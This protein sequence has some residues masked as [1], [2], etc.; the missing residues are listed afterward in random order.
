ML[1]PAEEPYH[2][3]LSGVGTHQT[4]DTRAGVFGLIKTIVKLDLVVK[5]VVGRG[6]RIGGEL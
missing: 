2:R 5:A 6:G 4:S 3:V 1:G